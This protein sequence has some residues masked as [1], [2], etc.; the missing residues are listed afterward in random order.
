MD[1]VVLGIR[2]AVYLQYMEGS[3]L[4]E[5]NAASHVR[6]CQNANVAQRIEY[7]VRYVPVCVESRGTMFATATGALQEG[8][9]DL[10]AHA[11]AACACGVSS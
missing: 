9:P 6:L 11:R 1:T 5:G 4:H 2:C 10:H 7:R 8:I 3:L